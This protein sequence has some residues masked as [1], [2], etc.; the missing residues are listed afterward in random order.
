M[1]ELDVRIID[2]ETMRV[3]SAHGFGKQQE[4]IA[5]EKLITW[6]EPK[7]LL[8]DH[9][10]HRIFGFNNPNPSPGSPNYG[11]EFQIVVGPEIEAEDEIKIKEVAAGKYA[12][13]RCQGIPNIG[14][15][16]Q[17]LASWRENSQR[18]ATI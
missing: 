14:K 1:S 10:A 15:R 7:G 8:E 5:R 6:A 16:W 17:Q 4:D 9:Q 18:G 3:A 2:L 12:V 11:Y 13:L